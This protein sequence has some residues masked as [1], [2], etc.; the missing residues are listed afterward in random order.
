M[1]EKTDLELAAREALRFMVLDKADEELRPYMGD[2]EAGLSAVPFVDDVERAEWRQD[3]IEALQ[4]ALRPPETSEEPAHSP[5]APTEISISPGV[6][7][8]VEEA[9]EPE[10]AAE[11]VPEPEVKPDPEPDPEPETPAVAEGDEEDEERRRC[12]NCKRK[13]PLTEFRSSSRSGDGITTRC[14]DCIDD[15]KRRSAEATRRRWER[16]RSEKAEPED[17]SDGGSEAEAEPAPEPQPEPAPEPAPKTLQSMRRTLREQ[18]EAE[19]K[20]SEAAFVEEVQEA[21]ETD[22]ADDEP[23]PES[24]PEPDVP[25]F[26]RRRRQAEETKNGEESREE[27]RIREFVTEQQEK[28][29]RGEDPASKLAQNLRAGRETETHD[30]RCANGAECVHYASIGK[31]AK[32]ADGNTDNLCFR[33]SE[34]ATEDLGSPGIVRRLGR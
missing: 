15:G 17:A 29:E 25:E 10:P 7:P 27:R 5:D 34:K 24:D 3:A 9:Q 6:E 18:R 20:E 8:E 11:E 14:G 28:A 32:L 19:R 1:T 21:E 23:E 26:T 4:R 22:P 2:E 13:R 33:C 16:H 30:R 31:P 12:V